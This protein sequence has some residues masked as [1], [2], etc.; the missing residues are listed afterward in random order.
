MFVSRAKL[1]ASALTLLVFVLSTS[2]LSASSV[3]LGDR[4]FVQ[5][6]EAEFANVSSRVFIGKN[7]IQTVAERVISDRA[8]TAL[9]NLESFV[10]SGLS[11]SEIQALKTDARV[12][13]VEQEVITPAPR[14]IEG[15][16]LTLPLMESFQAKIDVQNEL[17]PELIVRPGR[18][19]GI[20]AVKAAPAWAKSRMGQGAKV[21]VLDTGIDKAHPSIVGQIDKMQDFIGDENQPYPAADSVGHGTHVAGTILARPSA[22]GFVGVAPRARLL[23]GRVCSEEGCSNI[24]VANAINWAITE[25][26]DVINLSLGGMV[27]TR[28]EKM[29]VERAEASGVVVVAASGNDGEEIKG[30]ISFPAAFPTVLAVGAVNEN[31]VLASFSQYSAQLDVV[32]PGVDVVSSVPLGMAKANTVTLNLGRESIKVRS[33]TMDGSRDVIAGFSGEPVDCG[34]GEVSDFEK[35]DVSGKVAL[36]SRGK[37]LFVEKVKNAIAAGASAVVIYNN[38]EGLIKAQAT[39]SGE[40]V[41]VP[42]VII[43]KSSADRLLKALSVDSGV[44]KISIQTLASDYDSYSGTSMAAPHVSG[45]VALMKAS[46]RSLTPS[47]VRQIIKN[48]A[49]PLGPNLENEFGSGLVNADAAVSEAVALIKAPKQGK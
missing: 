31:S 16:R 42:A 2:N 12:E 25:K 21:A 41:S 19:W 7:Q 26:V 10:L 3:R 32:G 24:N 37:I 45:V 30:T 5:I 22:G 20:D 23:V 14:P 13:F 48:T 6:K 38:V 39:E 40:P 28:A 8:T 11:E 36:I 34:M 43:E 49:V 18:P 1:V 15:Y 4:Y 29:A 44:V 17:A 9:S 46:N 35:V 27:A 47:Q 33:V